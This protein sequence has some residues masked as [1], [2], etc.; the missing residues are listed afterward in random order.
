MKASHKTI[1]AIVCAGVLAALVVAISFWAFTQIETAAAARKHAYDVLNLADDWLS[2]LRDAE[3]GQRGFALTGDEAFLEPYLAVK[4]AVVGHLQDLRALTRIP[5]AQQR[6]DTITP[7]MTAKLAQMSSVIE[8][9]RRQDMS[10]VLV[11]VKSGEGRKLMDSIR[12]EMKGFVQI[13]E[14]IGRAHV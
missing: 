9:R 14:K 12:A 2:E 1:T 6:L 13:Q 10:A 3:T 11:A 5:S 7:L 4:D 8:L